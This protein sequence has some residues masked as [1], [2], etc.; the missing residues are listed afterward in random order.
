MS[1]IHLFRFG[2]DSNSLGEL[3]PDIASSFNTEEKYWEVSIGV[4]KEMRGC[5]GVRGCKWGDGL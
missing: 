2:P 1:H 4:V 3:G 5:K